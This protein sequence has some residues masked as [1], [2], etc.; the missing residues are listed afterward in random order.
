MKADALAQYLVWKRWRS[1]FLIHGT[2]EIDLANKAA[3]ERAAKKFGA[4]VVE[5][6]AYEYEATARR[7]DSG[8]VQI[9]TQLPVFT[10]GCGRA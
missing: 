9:Q 1:W 5:T 6:R 2:Q 8:H 10:Q 3:I 4:K 7:T